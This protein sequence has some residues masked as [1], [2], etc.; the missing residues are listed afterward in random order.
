MP[1]S[2]LDGRVASLHATSPLLVPSARGASG[3]RGPP[4]PGG[5]DFLDSLQEGVYSRRR[6]RATFFFMK[7]RIRT[8]K[9]MKRSE[10]GRN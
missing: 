8:I 5:E 6:A 4:G 1:T 9:V 10:C 2:V 7:V 3:A